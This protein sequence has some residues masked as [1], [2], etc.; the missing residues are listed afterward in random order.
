MYDELELTLHS[1]MSK[2][3]K[4]YQVEVDKGTWGKLS[5]DKQMI[6]AIQ[7]ELKSLKDKNLKVDT[8]F[9]KDI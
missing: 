5:D 8:S 1:L 6:V 9:D 4:A 3:L 2:L 7:S